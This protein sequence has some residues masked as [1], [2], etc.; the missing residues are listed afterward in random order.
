MMSIYPGVPRICTPRR[1]VHLRYPCI[2]VHPPSLI[3]DLLGGRD[4]ASWVMHME[5]VIERVWRCTCRLWSSEIGG[6]LGSGRFGGRRDGTWD[7]IH[8][9]TCNCGNVESWVQQ[10][11]PRDG[12]LAGSGRLSI[13]WWCCPLCQ[14]MIMAWRDREGWLNFVFLGDGRVEHKKVSDRGKSSWETGT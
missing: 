7:S 11:P 9:L 1:S 5:A 12:K 4:W 6:V 13:L 14:L 2:S 3:N 10:H 8:W